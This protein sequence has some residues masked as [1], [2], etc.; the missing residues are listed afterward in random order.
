MAALSTMHDTKGRRLVSAIYSWDIY[1]GYSLFPKQ[2]PEGPRCEPQSVLS[3]LWGPGDLKPSHVHMPPDSLDYRTEPLVPALSH[4]YHHNIK[5][6]L[7]WH[8]YSHW[9]GSVIAL[10][11]L[12]NAIQIDIV[13]CI[14]LLQLPME[15][16]QR[17]LI[18]L[19]LISVILSIYPVLPL[20]GFQS[21]SDGVV[22]RCLLELFYQKMLTV[23]ERGHQ[24]FVVWF[25]HV[26]I[27][28]LK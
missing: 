27:I 20:L 3:R 14:V 17:V 13:S 1:G 23:D 28:A 19:V 4:Y 25:C 18:F 11:A 16:I 10:L 21:S 5:K 26:T 9:L 12:W 22:K 6:K 2:A 7:I 24:G 8:N 15:V